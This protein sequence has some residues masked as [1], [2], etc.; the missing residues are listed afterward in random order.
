MKKLLLAVLI[1]ASFQA[2]AQPKTDSTT[3]V[4]TVALTPQQ[5]EAVRYVIDNSTLS[6][7][8]VKTVDAWLLKQLVQQL[9]VNS[10]QDTTKK[11]TSTNRH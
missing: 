11:A 10:V 3:K 7:Q 9:Q 5:W 1:A 6:H 2:S 8:D 4:L